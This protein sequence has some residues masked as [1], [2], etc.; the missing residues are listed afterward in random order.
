[1][2]SSLIK[3][4]TFF[5]YSIKRFPLLLIR[6]EIYYVSESITEIKRESLILSVLN[7]CDLSLRFVS[8][9]LRNRLPCKGPKQSVTVEARENR[10]TSTRCGVKV[11]GDRK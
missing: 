8:W 9:N 10:D 6:S 2:P 1:M 11:V 4:Y 5:L 3:I 7:V